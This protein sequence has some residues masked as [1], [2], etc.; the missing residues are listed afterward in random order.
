[1]RR[2]AFIAGIGGAVVWPVIARA[3]QRQNMPLVGVLSPGFTDPPGLSAFYGA[4]RDIGYT[5]G[6]NVRLERRYADWKPQQFAQLAAD[7]VRLKVDLIVVMSTS[8]ARAVQQATHTIPIVVAGT[9]DPVG[10]ELVAT[11]ARPGGNITGN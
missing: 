8:P 7:L 5:D 1:M 11:L 4:L 2:R 6:Q 9:A 3:Q 10:D